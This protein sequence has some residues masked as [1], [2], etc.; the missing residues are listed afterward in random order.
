MDIG[1]VTANVTR[2]WLLHLAYFINTHIRMRRAF[3]LE[4]ASLSAHSAPGLFPYP[5]HLIPA[6]RLQNGKLGLQRDGFKKL[7]KF[8]IGFESVGV[9]DIAVSIPPSVYQIDSNQALVDL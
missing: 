8:F 1:N 9:L 2:S 4:C 6:F 5:I 3:N 7:K